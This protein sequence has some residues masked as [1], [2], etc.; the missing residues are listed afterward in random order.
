MVDVVVEVAAQV[1]VSQ[2]TQ[3]ATSA[4]L[5]GETASAA[6]GTQAGA[7]LSDLRA[8]KMNEGAPMWMFSGR[9]ARVNGC[10]IFCSKIKEKEVVTAIGPGM[11]QIS[12]EYSVDIAIAWGQAA[13]GLDGFGKVNAIRQVILG[14]RTV[15]KVGKEDKYDDQWDEFDN[16]LGGQNVDP[17]EMIED[18]KGAKR[19]SGYRNTA[20]SYIDGLALADFGNAIPTVADAILEPNPAPYKVSDAL[21]DWWSRVPGRDADRDI[22]VSDVTGSNMIPEQEGGSYVF[23]GVQVEGPTPIGKTIAMIEAAYDVTHQHRNGVLCFFDRG[24]E[25][26]I[27]VDAGDLA[28]ADPGSADTARPLELTSLD[29]T[30]LPSQ[31]IVNYLDPKARYQRASASHFVNNAPAGQ[32]VVTIDL[33]MVLTKK[34]ARRIA[35]RRALEPYRLK[36]EAK[37][38]VPWGRYMHGLEADLWAVPFDGQVYYV[39]ALSVTLG[40]NWRIEV[41]G[42]VEEIRTGTDPIL[43]SAAGNLEDI[44]NHDD[45]PDD[46]PDQEDPD[47]ENGAQY[48]PPLMVKAIADAPPFTEGQADKCGFLYQ[49][50]AEDPG[51]RWKSARV[52]I[53][54]EADGPYHDLGDGLRHE[55][56]IGRVLGAYKNG[57]YQSTIPDAPEAAWGNF[58]D[59]DTKIR[60]QMHEGAL[61]TADDWLAV[62]G[63][64]NRAIVGGEIIQWL[65]A[66]PEVEQTIELTGL[67]MQVV[68]PNLIK[69]TVAGI[70]FTTV[71]EVGNYVGVTGFLENANEAI[72]LKATAV[73]ADQITLDVSSLSG[74][75]FPTLVNEGPLAADTV[76]ELRVSTG[77]YVISGL[78]R[79]QMD[80]A[81]HAATHAVGELFMVQEQG[82]TKF[83]E[84]PTGKI[85]KDRWIKAVP[86]R[87]TKNDVAPVGFTLAGECLRPWRP[88]YVHAFRGDDGT[89][90]ATR[91]LGDAPGGSS[92]PGTGQGTASAD[93]TLYCLHRTRLPGQD[94]TATE[95]HPLVHERKIDLY[96]IEV[97]KTS[98]FATIVR[99]VDVEAPDDHDESDDTP[100]YRKWTYTAA[101]QSSDGFFLTD[102]VYLR[103]Q[104]RG[105]IKKNGN[106]ETLF[107]RPHV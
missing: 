86:K 54:P 29:N 19:T 46:D 67:G 25:G 74:G 13:G 26:V 63:G 45:D 8:V 48:T 100:G 104:Q 32:N 102:G 31:L 16:S 21:R 105:G 80:T 82:V 33:P 4:L 18:S 23:R 98:S 38:S 14:G 90:G 97:S 76:I 3:A 93:I 52:F 77:I 56:P 73:V 65:T 51:K 106:S 78:L 50:C 22:D 59:L 66:T 12:F 64:E 28:T 58:P 85:G 36:F 43:S 53:A 55:S 96:R 57:V 34:A 9:R 81:D 10:V 95:N 47:T 71:V 60:V 20:V 68:A 17:S 61:E 49:H 88:A 6:G 92:T 79:G 101:Q 1:V 75:L 35:K 99:T 70:D 30:A 11:E 5:G 107:V 40:A 83:I 27:E 7:K 15:W 42:M 41:R 72:Y 39:R 2:A 94:P 62:Y 84:Q 37:F 24:K 89:K 103:I 91:G 69:R 87:A 44:D